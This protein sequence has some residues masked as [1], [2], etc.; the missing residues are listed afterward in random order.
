[1]HPIAL[2]QRLEIMLGF[3][4]FFTAITLISTIVG[5]VQGETGLGPSL[6]LLVCATLFLTAYRKWRRLADPAPAAFTSQG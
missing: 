6:L 3:T 1:M 4:G 2:R 5:I